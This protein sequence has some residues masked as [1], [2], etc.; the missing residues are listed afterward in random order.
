MN[1]TANSSIDTQSTCDTPIANST[2]TLPVEIKKLPGQ[3]DVSLP[4][5]QSDLAAGMDLHA[6]VPADASI[7]IQ[8]GDIA[9]IPCGF[10][11]GVVGVSSRCAGRTIDV[12][13]A[14]EDGIQRPFP[15]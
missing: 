11:M 3:E 15:P 9:L 5:Y 14:Q 8:P 10:A 6:A 7:T 1:T 4:A 12:Q 13:S 2:A